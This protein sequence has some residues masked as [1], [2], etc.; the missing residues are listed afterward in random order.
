MC[1]VEGEKVL[2]S[3]QVTQVHLLCF[4]CT[5][6]NFESRIASLKLPSVIINTKEPSNRTVGS[7]CQAYG[8][9]DI[10]SQ[11]LLP[12][13]YYCH[14]PSAFKWKIMGSRL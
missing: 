14:L 7:S 9:N 12:V 8:V 1:G 11:I 5:V 4:V 2:V 3:A 10:F 13:W 6:S